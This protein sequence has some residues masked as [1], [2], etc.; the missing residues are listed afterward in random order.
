MTGNQVAWAR[1]WAAGVLL[2]LLAGGAGCDDSDSPAD[3]GTASGIF[4]KVIDSGQRPVADAVV[5]TEPATRSGVTDGLGT[6]L[7]T[8]VP[9]GIYAVTAQHAT[10][11]AARMPVTVTAS[12]LVQVTL[13]LQPPVAMPGAPTAHILM[14]TSGRRFQRGEAITFRAQVADDKDPPGQLM[15]EWTSSLDGRLSVAPAG[16]DGISELTTGALT[17][18]AHAITL[19]VKDAEGLSGSALVTVVVESNGGSVTDA[20]PIDAPA[21]LGDGS[22]AELGSP[23]D[24]PAD[25]AGNLSIVLQMPTQD[26]NGVSLSWTPMPDGAIASYRVYRRGQTGSFEVINIISNPATRTHRDDSALYGINYAYRVDGL[27]A[28]GQV[29]QSNVQ[30]AMVGAFI[31]LNT[32]VTAMLVDRTRPYLY[33]L[34][35]VNNSLH[36]V[37]LNSKALEK[38]IFVGS[39]PADLD[40]NLANSELFIANFGS[41]EITVVNLETRD[42]ARSLL[43][44]TTAG[45]WDG[46]PYRLVC[47]AGD[48]LVFTSDDQWNDL[49]LVNATDG[50]ALA[51]TASVF[52]PDLATSPDGTRVY[53]GE[54]GISRSTVYRFDVMGSTLMQVDVSG[55]VGGFTTRN[56][57]V[58]R[59]GMYVFYAGQKF[60]A[61]NLKSVLGTFGEP[62][63]ASNSDGSIVVGNK[64]IFDGNTFAMV[65][66][67]PITP[68]A[69]ALGPDDTTLYI[70]DSGSSRIYLHRLR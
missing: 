22:A 52:Q 63:L 10:L 19:K 27:T 14:P 38:T 5:S 43:V 12:G 11:G 9:A 30:M 59:N 37:N 67:L 69:I 6:V 60:L 70:Y 36:F 68:A 47:T 39:R 49:K 42:K 18:G 3:A 24:A 28:S 57:V 7:L 34:D 31:A 40:V 4:V 35:T 17:A 26:G 64:H 46:N 29:V 58:S 54:S 48:T 25:V 13:V 21:D 8:G 20:G 51:H 33:A 32:Q 66:P 55:D 1:G 23:G 45:T 61:N 15:I 65:R 50:S 2:A 41:T 16:A 53:V 56:V 44:N 62:I